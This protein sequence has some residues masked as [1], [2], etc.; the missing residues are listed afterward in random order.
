MDASSRLSFILTGQ[1]PVN[2]TDLTLWERLQIVEWAVDQTKSRLPYLSGFERLDH[3]ASQ[4]WT[5][6]E[7]YEVESDIMQ[8]Y[9]LSA[10]TLALRL[11]CIDDA[12]EG[13]HRDGPRRDAPYR[14]QTALYLTR[15]GEWAMSHIRFRNGWGDFRPRRWLGTKCEFSLVSPNLL[16]AY[17]GADNKLV[18]TILSQLLRAT[19]TALERRRRQLT[20]LEALASR[21]DNTLERAGYGLH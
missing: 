7:W 19:N 5:N 6:S 15:D 3:W 8:W 20:G 11:H 1:R 18:A 14:T 9:D 17:L 10:S 12:H 16:K 4:P 21:L 2:Y 13:V